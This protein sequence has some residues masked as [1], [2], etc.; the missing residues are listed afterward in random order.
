MHAVIQLAYQGPHKETHK[1]LPRANTVEIPFADLHDYEAAQ[2]EDQT[3]PADPYEVLVRKVTHLAELLN[4][5]EQ[6]AE[7]VLFARIGQ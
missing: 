7:R 6:E 4:I 2:V 1:R 5:S 3:R